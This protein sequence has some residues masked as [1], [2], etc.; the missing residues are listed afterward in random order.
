MCLRLRL[1]DDPQTRMDRIDRMKERQT[2]ARILFIPVNS[3]P[4]MR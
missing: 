2:L 4:Y 3:V 1:R